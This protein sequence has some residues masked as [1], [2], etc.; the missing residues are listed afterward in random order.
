MY[1]RMWTCGYLKELYCPSILARFENPALPT[2]GSV[3]T[4][5]LVSGNYTQMTFLQTI[6]ARGVE[7][8]Y[9][10]KKQPTN[11]LAP[12]PPQPNNPQTFRSHSYSGK[13][14]DSGQYGQRKRV[15]GCLLH[16][17][18]R[19]NSVRENLLLLN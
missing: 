1:I 8:P 2:P 16:F 18:H 3:L 11:H 10:F 17:L 19:I 4:S 6:I 5:L 13:K 9:I 12:P 14:L 7:D 15:S